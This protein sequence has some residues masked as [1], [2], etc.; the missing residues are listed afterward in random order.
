MVVASLLGSTTTITMRVSFLFYIVG[1]AALVASSRGEEDEGRYHGVDVH[2][3]HDE[4]DDHHHHHHHGHHDHHDHHHHEDMEYPRLR[5]RYALAGTAVVTLGGNLSII[6]VMYLNLS[7]S[8]LKLMVSFAVGGLLGDVFLHLLPHA[9]SHDH[10]HHHDGED[11]HGHEHTISD[12]VP[13]LCILLG[14]FVFFLFEKYLRSRGGGHGHS[15]DHAY[16][17]ENEKHAD[18]EYSEQRYNLRRRTR[19]AKS[20]APGRKG[21][22]KKSEKNRIMP[23]AFLNLAADAVHNFTDGMAI[24]AAF[25]TSWGV[26]KAMTLAVLLHEIPHEIGDFAVLV[27]QGFSKRDAFLAQFVSAAGAFAGCCFGLYSALDPAYVLC[28]TAGGFIYISLVNILP[29]LHKD[30]SLSQTCAECVCISC[31]VSMMIAIALMEP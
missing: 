31:G 9:A 20:T 3:H 17:D 11:D 30:T 8:T 16:E 28:F 24:A 10:H 5:G 25:D 7:K 29:D 15:H 6:L 23:G 18:D 12:L 27:T 26:G 13:G 22:I 14:I 19:A 1:A 4:D 2:H 21:A